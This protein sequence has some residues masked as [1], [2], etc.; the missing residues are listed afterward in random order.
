MT[1]EARTEHQITI[2]TDF[3]E[4]RLLVESK[5]LVK[6]Q[7]WDTAGQEQFRAITR[8]FYRDAHA[9]LVVFDLTNF[10]TFDS[11][12]DWQQ[13]IRSNTETELV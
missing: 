13:E 5:Y 8:T 4:Y 6:L 2:G 3:G 1:N 11:L 12:T 7:I 10:S 9:A